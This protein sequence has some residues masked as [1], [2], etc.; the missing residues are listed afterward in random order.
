MVRKEEDPQG[1]QYVNFNHLS[2][3]LGIVTHYKLGI[4]TGAIN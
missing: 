1:Y 2:F 3:R 4:E